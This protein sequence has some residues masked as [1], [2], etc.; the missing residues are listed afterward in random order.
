MAKSLK[1]PVLGTIDC[2]EC[3]AQTNVK[4]RKLGR[5]GT[6][7]Q[8]FSYC[9]SCNHMEQ[10][11]DNITQSRLKDFMPLIVAEVPEKTNLETPIKGPKATE[12]GDFVGDSEVEENPVFTNPKP[13]LKTPIE[14]PKKPRKFWLAAGLLSLGGALIAIARV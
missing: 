12:L 6:T 14:N 10:K 3:G 1:S 11:G 4:R 2:S 5:G 7:K 13:L 9:P 8:Y